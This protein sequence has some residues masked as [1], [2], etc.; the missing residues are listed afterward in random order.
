MR[1]SEKNSTVVLLIDRDGINFE[2]SLNPE[3]YEAVTSNGPTLVL[4]GAGTGKTRVLVYRVAWLIEKQGEDPRSIVLLTFTKKAADEMKDRV[5]IL[6]KK[7]IGRMVAGGTFHSFA[8]TILRQYA[9]L[10]GLS[11]NFIILDNPDA[12][13]VIDIIRTDLGYNARSTDFPY[14]QRIFEIISISRNKQI[15]I[16]AVVKGKFSGLKDFIPDL[17]LIRDKYAVYKKDK[18]LLDFDDMIEFLV[19]AL[20]E[21]PAFRK[22]INR[23]FQYVMVDE[24]QDTNTMQFELVRLLSP[25]G[26][27]V[28]A[29]GDDMQ[30]IYAFRGAN[31][32]NI[33][34][35]P[36]SFPDCKIVKLEQNYRS[37]PE[38][39]E[40]TNAI[41]EKALTGYPKKLWSKK[42]PGPK[43]QVANFDDTYVEAEFIADKVRALKETGIPTSEIAILS[44]NSHCNLYVQLELS[45]RGIPYSVFGGSKFSE[46]KHVKDLMAYLRIAQ[47][48]KDVIAWHRVL[49]LLPGI[50]PKN[51]DK[52]LAYLKDDG[53]FENIPESN[54]TRQVRELGL[55]I[56]QILPDE[57]PLI[58]KI[59]HVKSHYIPILELKDKDPEPKKIDINMIQQTSAQYSSVEKFIS[60]FVLNPPSKLMVPSVGPVI[61]ETEEPPVVISTIHSAKGLEWHAVFVIH[62]LEGTIPSSK[63]MFG[64]EIEE[65]RR[66]FYVACTRAK[67]NLFVTYPSYLPSYNAYFQQPSRFLAELD[68]SNF[69]II[70]QVFTH[71]AD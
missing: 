61:D 3:Q 12:E 41:I 47:N 63:A 9:K 24:F 13:D 50:G 60:D 4:A 39:L 69:E 43:T 16:E 18:S 54:Y 66:L 17:E 65:E 10:I 56:K 1:K 25:K 31:Y 37:Q 62:A 26:N 5:S 28:M 48:I 44:R 51:A 11:P 68:A 45:K 6:V 57:V 33:F 64:E 23:R 2:A 32:E 59:E 36:K 34:L 29:V 55:V 20:K 22:T 35:F 27:N 30:S 42:K 70:E 7:N 40:F 67:E 21:N 38:L 15:S 8:N 46:R 49:K 52:I 58:D 19:I 71:E 53:S 14:K